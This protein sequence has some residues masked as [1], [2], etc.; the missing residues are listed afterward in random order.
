MP[1]A[2]GALDLPAVRREFCA[3]RF[4]NCFGDARR[5]ARARF[6]R[7]DLNPAEGSGLLQLPFP[8]AKR[9]GKVADS[10]GSGILVE[11]ALNAVEAF[12]AEC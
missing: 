11:N 10:Q 2:D 9:P 6:M 7:L 1:D 8:N 5:A 4:A 12:A 3:L